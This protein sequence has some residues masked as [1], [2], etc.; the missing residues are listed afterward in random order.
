MHRTS[1]LLKKM[2]FR[3][4]FWRCNWTTTSSCL[5]LLTTVHLASHSGY[6]HKSAEQTVWK[7]EHGRDEAERPGSSFYNNS[8]LFK[9]S[10]S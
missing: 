5:M 3:S 10:Q 4:E 8:L 7:T 1:I 6:T 9:Q 2:Y